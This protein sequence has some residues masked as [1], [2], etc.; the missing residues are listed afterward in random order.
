MISFIRFFIRPPIF[1]EIVIFVLV[2]SSFAPDADGIPGLYEQPTEL[3]TFIF[4]DFAKITSEVD[5]LFFQ[6]SHLLS[7]QGSLV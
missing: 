4:I 6:T 7:V 1:N 3:Q 5:F 2:S